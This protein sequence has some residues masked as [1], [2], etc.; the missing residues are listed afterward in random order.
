VSVAAQIEVNQLGQF[1]RKRPARVRRGA[2]PQT[3][4]S[5]FDDSEHYVLTELGK[6]FVHYTMNEVISRI[7]DKTDQI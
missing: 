3:L 1:I 2:G 6:Q 5:A 7:G 4:K